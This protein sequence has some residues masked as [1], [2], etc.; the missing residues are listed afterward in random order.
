LDDRFFTEEDHLE[1]S[2]LA[3]IAAEVLMKVLYGA[4]TCRPDL[5]FA[6][7][8]LVREVA[9]WTCAYDKRL[10]RFIYYK[11]T[12]NFSLYSTVGDPL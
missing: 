1:R 4:R 9:G 10:H 6:V 2:A 3:P 7:C 8:S 11:C 12:F 5:L